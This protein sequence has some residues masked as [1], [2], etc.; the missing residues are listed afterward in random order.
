MKLNSQSKEAREDNF[1]K[2]EESG[3]VNTLLGKKKTS[4]DYYCEMNPDASECR[5]YDI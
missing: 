1:R 5:M 4:L 3:P 2:P